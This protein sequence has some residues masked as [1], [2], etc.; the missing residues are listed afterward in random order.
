MAPD[1]AVRVHPEARTWLSFSGSF[2]RFKPR[3]PARQNLL[4]HSEHLTMAAYVLHTV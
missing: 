4:N 2:F 1:T 3:F